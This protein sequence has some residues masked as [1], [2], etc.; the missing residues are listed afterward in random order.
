VR[1]GRRR[2]DGRREGSHG[3]H[4]WAKVQRCNKVAALET[5]RGRGAASR[6]E[7]TGAATARRL[8]GVKG[9]ALRGREAAP[10]HSGALGPAREEGKAVSHGGRTRGLGADEMQ[11]WGSPFIGASTGRDRMARGG[12]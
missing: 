12:G 5:N 11:R 2:L 3:V 8:S 4:P 9:D 1:P 7:L 10:G 6:R